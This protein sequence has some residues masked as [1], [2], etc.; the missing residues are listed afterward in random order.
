MKRFLIILS[1]AFG[2]MILAGVGGLV[3]IYYWAASDLPDFKNI[4]DYN[5][6]L[7]TT[8]YANDDQVLGYFYKE[9]RFLVTMD[10]ISHWVP[11]AFLAA[12]DSSFYEHEGVDLSAIFR[13]FVKNLQAGHVVQGGSTITQQVIK[14]LLLTPEKSYQRKLKEAILAYRLERYLTKD[15]ILTIYMNQIFF[16]SHAYGIESAAREYFGKHAKDLTLA[17]A[18]LLAG[19]PKAP[20]RYN[21]YHAPEIAKTRQHYVLDRM[22]ETGF[23]DRD[24]Y[25]YALEQPLEYKGDTDPSWE[26]GAYYLEEVRRWLIDR[27]GEETV[28]TAGMHVYTAA[29]IKHLEAAEASVK[30]GLEE[31]AK[32]RGWEGAPEHLTEGQYET[33][34]IENPVAAEDLASGKW[35]K[36]LVQAVDEQGAEVRF[37][38]YKGRI[39]VSTMAW[40]REP[41]PS[42]AP[43]D[44]RDVKDARKVLKPGDV[45]WASLVEPLAAEELSGDGE[46]VEGKLAELEKRNW[47][48]ALEKLPEV[49]G[50]LVSVK[51]DTGEVLALVGGY[52]FHRSQFN[53]ATQAKRQ[54]GSAFKPFVYSAALDNGFTPSSVVLDAPIV[55]QDQINDRLWKPE[56]FEGVF[57][58]PTL[59]RTALVKSRNLV[60]I[61][62]AKRLGIET[63]IQRAKD[64]GL[65]ADFPHDLSVSLGSGSV[66]LMNLCRAYTAFARMGSYVE[67]RMVLR[68][69]SA[70]GDELFTSEFESV[71]AISPQTAF[72][73]DRLL[74]EVVSDGT[75]WRARALGRP[76]AGKTGTTNEEQ[77]AWF[78][79][80]TPY[81]LTGA[82]VGFDQL[83]P[84]GK[85]E[86]GSRAA[87]PLWVEYRKAVE[88]E[89]P[90]QDFRQPPGVVM[91]RIDPGTG[92]LA[93]PGAEESYFL[94]FKA[95][96]QPIQ[97]AQD[98]G[99]DG[100]KPGGAAPG[101][102]DLMKQ[103]F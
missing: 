75:G 16:G 71:E 77:D 87:A 30:Q 83:T 66:S 35:F 78:V 11:K 96:T 14:R 69:E 58:G 85:W 60:T 7:V 88:D 13:A 34:F 84:M 43:E 28:Y 12:E 73:I 52:D 82:Y 9:K 50:A 97:T 31:S 103:V 59:L 10:E 27:F 2:L 33:F 65:E 32:R 4:T 5:P 68:V 22:L 67:P 63:I 37:G 95:G 61:R 24:Q 100:D 89:Y 46:Q 94:P 56:N 26:R 62:V 29:D 54:P 39:S 1:I 81:L 86:T 76:V 36:V 99:A 42:K 3:G 98:F 70:W 19:L 79:G 44:V 72:I 48:L 53:R 8:V 64:M 45:V 92:L 38:D 49:Q 6:P 102:E 51:P 57:Y 21:P 40:C 15:E 91:A 18:A 25:E 80:F 20:S 55:Y 90:V 17:E 101:G 41:D 47:E 74:Q 93:G 23:I